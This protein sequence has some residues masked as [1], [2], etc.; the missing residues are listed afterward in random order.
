MNLTKANY[1]SLEADQEYMSASQFKDFLRCEARALAKLKGE[2]QNEA[3]SAM[4]VGSYVDAY[5][6]Q[7]LE[8][9]EQEHPEIF[10]KDGK[11]LKAEF[12]GAKAMIDRALQDDVFMGYL[13]GK[14]QEILTGEIE[15]VPFKAMLDVYNPIENRIVDLKTT[16]DFRKVWSEESNSFVGFIEAWRYDLQGAV[17]RELV[18]Q[19]TGKDASFFIAGI[20]REST[21]DIELFEV[22]SDVLDDALGEIRHR[23]GYFSAL[24]GEYIEPK[25]CGHCDYCKATKT[26]TAPIDFRDYDWR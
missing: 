26:L 23:C 25:R 17:Y 10:L 19:S 15:G 21:P 18:R 24:K 22:P 14:Q 11:T 5:F 4:L 20:T 13:D 2:V 8:A 3:S 12:R 6:T 1:Y 7:D 9:F 16:R